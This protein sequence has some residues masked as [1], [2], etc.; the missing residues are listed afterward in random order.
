MRGPLRVFV[1]FCAEAEL[2]DPIKMTERN[3]ISVA[4]FQHDFNNIVD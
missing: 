1:F 4:K 3:R 2:I